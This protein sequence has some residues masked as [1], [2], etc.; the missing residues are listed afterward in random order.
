MKKNTTGKD[1]SVLQDLN[2]RYDAIRAILNAARSS[3]ALPMDIPLNG[4]GAVWLPAGD[5]SSCHLCF[6]TDGEEFTFDE[7][8]IAVDGIF[9][10]VQVG[11]W[12]L[13]VNDESAINGSPSNH[14]A[15]GI[16]GQPI[17][18]DVLVSPLA[19]VV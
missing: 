6:P 2:T 3:R 8:K 10:V 18:G 5:P 9:D 19:W 7:L 12:C 17:F 15:T 4:M 13:V 11:H 1:R 14:I 16:A